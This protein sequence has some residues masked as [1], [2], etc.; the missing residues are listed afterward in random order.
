MGKQVSSLTTIITAAIVAAV[1]SA[2]GTSLFL[3]QKGGAPL[4]SGTSGGDKGQIEKIVHD[5]LLANP[6]VLIEMSTKL[7]AQGLQQQITALSKELEAKITANSDKLYRSERA[8]VAG[9]PNGDVTIVE[10]TDYNCGYCR[11]SMV[12]VL[13][14]IESD[15]NVRVVLKE[16][17]IFGREPSEEAA[18]VALATRK[19]NKYME[20]HVA[21]FT[22]PGPA[23]K[24]K[25]LR[26]AKELGL[27][28]EQLEKDIES[29]EVKAALDE[30][31][32]LT[33]ELGIEG[34]PF[35][36]VG[37][38]VLPGGP[39]NL[40]DVLKDMVAEVRKNGCSATC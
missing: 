19:Q 33:K 12:D 38:R 26:V 28:M 11:R 2:V 10:F 1:V 6:Q 21:M 32:E 5:Y 25:A 14:L 22:A 4:A 8:H 30:N 18:R 29:D 31:I 9:N 36:L 15:K 27:D 35:F 39:D 7:Q 24:A 17:P 13:K 40:Q 16:A 37:D 20:F 3:K 23:D 34:T